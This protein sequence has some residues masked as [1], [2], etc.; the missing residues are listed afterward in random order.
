LLRQDYKEF[1]EPT[2]PK[3][4]VRLLPHFDPYL[5]AHTGK[6]HLLADAY[7]K[8]VY[9]N[10]GWISPVILVNGRVTGV[11]LYKIQGRTLLIQIAPFER[12]SRAIRAEIEQEAAALAAFFARTPVIEFTGTK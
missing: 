7:Y 3:G 1:A 9:R 2:A 12:L 10:Q 4:T 5:L 8:R 6:E 11:W